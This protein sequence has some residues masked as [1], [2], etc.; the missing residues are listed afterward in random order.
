MKRALGTLRR[1]DGKEQVTAL[2]D[3]ASA[4]APLH[5]PHGA[6]HCWK[7]S[8]THTPKSRPRHL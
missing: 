1:A 4:H 7:A 8:E 2:A 5:N 3:R 6:A